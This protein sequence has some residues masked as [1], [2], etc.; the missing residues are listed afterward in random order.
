MPRA[1]LKY[2]VPNVISFKNIIV[3]ICLHKIIQKASLFYYIEQIRGVAVFIYTF[4]MGAGRANDNFSYTKTMFYQ[5]HFIATKNIMKNVKN[6][7]LE[8]VGKAIKE[9]RQ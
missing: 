6:I 4:G 7:N 8:R 2:R 5:G 9:L 3:S 1:K